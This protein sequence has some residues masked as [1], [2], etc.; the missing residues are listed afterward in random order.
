M[1]LFP[2]LCN[3]IKRFIPRIKCDSPEAALSFPYHTE[4]P[5]LLL[6]GFLGFTCSILIPL[7]LP[8]LLVYF[9]LAYFVYRNQVRHFSSQLCFAFML[10]ELQLAASMLSLWKTNYQVDGQIYV[11]AKNPFFSY[12]LFSFLH[13]SLLGYKYRPQSSLMLPCS[14]YCLFVIN[15]KLQRLRRKTLRLMLTFY[16]FSSRFSTS[17]FQ[18]MKAGGSFGLLFTIQ[19][20]FPWF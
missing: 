12:L 15:I 16:S 18:N 3:L 8:F 4:I 7:I 9:V 20:S 1:Q 6:F 10:N 17:T 19:Q 2:L 13:F 5:R 14:L 11:P